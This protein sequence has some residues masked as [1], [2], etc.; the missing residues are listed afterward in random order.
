VTTRLLPTLVL[1]LAA[2][3]TP[4]RAWK[5]PEG[6][7]GDALAGVTRQVTLY[8]G[9]DIMLIAYATEETPAFQVAR[10]A[11]LADLFH[12]PLAQAD[13]R[14]TDLTEATDGPSFVFALHTNER[15][16]NDL[17]QSSSHWALTLQ[18]PAGPVLPTRIHR[19]DGKTPALTA[20][21]PYADR[22]FVPYRVTFPASVAAGPHQLV[23][24]GPLGQAQ[25]TF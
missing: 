2:C 3:A 15:G 8:N 4:P 7:Y 21:Y 1:V 17:D 22:F 19:V 24:S 14:S 23:L 20:L 18:T 16:W 11:R 6:A 9:I 10:A 5:P 12:V 13:A 25:L